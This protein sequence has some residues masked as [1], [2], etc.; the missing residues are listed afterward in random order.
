MKWEDLFLNGSLID[1]DIS[2]WRGQRKLLP[3]D[4]N[5]EL[6]PAAERVFSLG[7]KRLIPKEKMVSF[8][9]VEHAARKAVD[10]ASLPFPLAGARF[11]PTEKVAELEAGLVA[12]RSEFE[13]SARQFAFEY[14]QLREEV[15]PVLVEAA[16]EVWRSIANGNGTDREVFEQQFLSRIESAYPDPRELSRKFRFRWRFFAITAPKN[17]TLT[18]ETAIEATERDRVRSDIRRRVIA[19]EE[20]EVREVIASMAKDLR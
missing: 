4:L 9:K 3:E 19:S 17:G 12:L 6:G 7:R 1:L 15:R 10:T 18:E 8:Q 16:D 5:L 20:S 2:F 11:I 13:D 14:P